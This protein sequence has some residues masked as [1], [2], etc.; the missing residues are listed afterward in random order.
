MGEGNVFILRGSNEENKIDYKTVHLGDINYNILSPA[1]YVSDD[2]EGESPDTRYARIHEQCG[3]IRFK[4]GSDVK[5]IMITGDADYDAW[6]KHISDYHKE[7]L[8]SFILSA[9]HHGSRTFFWK[10]SN[11]D[12]P[13]YKEHLKTI[14]PTYIIVSAPKVKESKHDH[15][16]EEAMELYREQVG[17]DNVFHLG[18]KRECI[19]VDIDKDGNP[20]LYPD[21]ELVKSYGE[22]GGGEQVKLLFL[23]QLVELTKSQWGNKWIGFQGIP[24]GYVAKL[25]LS[26]TAPSIRKRFNL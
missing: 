2:V 12:S 26:Q 24:I 18:D 22:S 14:D 16:H 19:I 6:E 8:P 17:S 1:D 13:A 15:P 11:T 10:D 25:N 9:A 7:R 3:V 23:H 4:Y 21:K 5:E 20:D